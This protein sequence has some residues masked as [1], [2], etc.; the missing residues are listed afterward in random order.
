MIVLEITPEQA[1]DKAKNSYL[2]RIL[3]QQSLEQNKFKIPVIAV[4]GKGEQRQFIRFGQKFWVQNESQAVE[5][6]QEAGYLVHCQPLLS[7]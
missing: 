7:N 2:K 6:L 4:I 1:L 3:E 5:S